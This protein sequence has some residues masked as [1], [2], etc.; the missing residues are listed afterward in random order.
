M[1]RLAQVDYE[2]ESVIRELAMRIVVPKMSEFDDVWK[3]AN[4]VCDQYGLVKKAA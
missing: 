1:S 2:L 4:R 3:T